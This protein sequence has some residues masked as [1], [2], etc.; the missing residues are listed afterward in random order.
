LLNLYHAFSDIKLN[1]FFFLISLKFACIAMYN[2]SEKQYPKLVTNTGFYE[3]D[4]DFCCVYRR[5]DYVLPASAVVR[6]IASW[7]T[8]EAYR[9]ISEL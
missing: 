1:A 4:A 6:E 3:K 7:T 2:S 8:P 5:I 9:A